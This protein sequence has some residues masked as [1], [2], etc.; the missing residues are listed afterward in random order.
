LKVRQKII[1]VAASL[2]Y[3]PSTIAVSHTLLRDKLVLQSNLKPFVTFQELTATARSVSIVTD[4]SLAAAIEWLTEYGYL[5]HDENRNN[6]SNKKSKFKKDSIL[7]ASPKWMLQAIGAILTSKHS[8]ITNGEEL[9]VAHLP[10][11]WKPPAYPRV[12]HQALVNLFESHG[13]WTRSTHAGK[14]VLRLWWIRDV[15]EGSVIARPG[16][17]PNSIE[18]V[19]KTL[20]LDKYLP[21]FQKQVTRIDNN[22]IIL[23][24]ANST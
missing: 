13:V 6:S 7:V 17:K 5:I 3:I 20:E 4:A 11:I 19:L 14:E 10:E 16:G 2:P 15:G 24:P 21:V 23:N 8:F 9:D 18:A 12:V 22:L 1:D